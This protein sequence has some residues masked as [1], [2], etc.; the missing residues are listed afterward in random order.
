MAT[1]ER[2]EP[3]APCYILLAGLGV[4]LR[5]AEGAAEDLLLSCFGPTFLNAGANECHV[6]A[7]AWETQ[8]ARAQFLGAMALT[9]RTSN[10]EFIR[11]Q[12]LYIRVASSA[13]RGFGILRAEVAFGMVRGAVGVPFEVELY[14]K[15]GT[16]SQGMLCGVVSGY[17]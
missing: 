7:R 6:E 14:S 8:V 10:V 5:H 15:H 16:A 11:T 13:F 2:N 3:L 17:P 4:R 12:K 9:C 1:L